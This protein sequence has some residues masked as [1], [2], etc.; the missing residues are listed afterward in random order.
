MP[1]PIYVASSSGS[2]GSAAA[3]A[4]VPISS[5]SASSSRATAVVERPLARG[6]GGSEILSVVTRLTSGLPDQALRAIGRT[7]IVI[8]VTDRDGGRVQNQLDAMLVRFGTRCQVV[9]IRDLADVARV[10]GVFLPG[11]MAD[12]PNTLDEAGRLH[13][14]P[15]VDRDQERWVAR[16]ELQYRVIALAIANNIP[17]LGVC[18]GSRCLAQGVYGGSTRYLAQRDREVHNQHFSQPW[19]VAHEIVIAPGSR[20]GRIVRGGHYRSGPAPDTGTR[21]AVN[22]M[23]WAQSAFTPQSPVRISA[24]HG[25]VL[26]GWELVGHPFFLG[27]QWHPEFAQLPVGDFQRTTQP[28]VHVMAALG[29][30]AEEFEAAR[31]LQAAIRCWAVRR[32]LRRWLAVVDALRTI[33]GTQGVRRGEL[34]NPRTLAMMRAL[35][36]IRDLLDLTWQLR[37]LDGIDTFVARAREALVEVRRLAWKDDSISVADAEIIDDAIANIIG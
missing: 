28:H 34:D 27:L 1:R 29:D 30:A 23:H 36:A 35:D 17:I 18:G 5:A 7:G 19:N 15:R 24:T 33:E 31:I 6:G 8:G 21:I 37:A 10:H 25:G 2:S 3:A 9:V 13:Q 32:C 20:L 26:E 4:A 22:S 12:L 16:V 11:G 14:E